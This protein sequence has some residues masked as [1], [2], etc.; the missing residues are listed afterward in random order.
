MLTAIRTQPRAW[1]ISLSAA[2]AEK[3]T[4][5]AEAISPLSAQ[6]KSVLKLMC[7]QC[8]IAIITAVLTPHRADTATLCA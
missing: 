1:I 8:G 6:G 4:D 5:S 3:C 2:P 7:F